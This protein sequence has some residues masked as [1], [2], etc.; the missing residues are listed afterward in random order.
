MPVG[1]LIRTAVTAVGLWVATLLVSGITVSGQSA[2]AEAWTLVLVA[3]IFGLV[4]AIIS[5][6]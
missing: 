1:F 3:I 5:R 6:S 2:W 4:N